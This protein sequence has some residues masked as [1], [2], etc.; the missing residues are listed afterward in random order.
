MEINKTLAFTGHRPN[1][2]KGYKMSENTELLKVLK[3][4]I[5][6]YIEEKGVDTFVSGMA[7]GVDIWSAFIVLKLKEKHPSIKLVCAV[8]CDKQYAVWKNQDDIDDWKYIIDNA[9]VV[10]YVST[11][12]YTNWC[13]QKR[14]EW[15]VD[16]SDY[17][18]AIWNGITNG[19]TWNCIKYAM[20]KDTDILKIDSN[21]LEIEKLTIDKCKK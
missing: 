1:R 21:T 14:N 10:H 17:V 2:L 7:L 4:T 19:G 5:I 13:L 6:Y 11:E 9:D 15:M 18:L 8:P 12:P 3:D 20:K 16:N